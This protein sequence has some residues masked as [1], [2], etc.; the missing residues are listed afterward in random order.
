MSMHKVIAIT[1]WDYDDAL[2]QT[3]TLPYVRIITE[4]LESPKDLTLVTFDKNDCEIKKANHREGDKFRRVSFRYTPFGLTSILRM[5]FATIK[6]YI[7]CKVNK[8]NKIHVWGSTAGS[9]GFFLSKILKSELIIDSF[10]PHAESMVENGTWDR[11][12]FQFR[13][14]FYLE[15]LQA[16]KASY[17]IG[18]SAGML[19]YACANYKISKK[20][21]FV[22]PSCVDLKLFNPDNVKLKREELGFEKS[23]IIC[24]YAGKFGGIYLDQEIFD[25]FHESLK[26]FGKRFKVLLLTNETKDR[27][28]K[29]Q[30]KSNIPDG[31]IHSHFLPHH[32]VPEYM[33]IADFAINPV[34]PVPTKRYCTSIKDGEYWAMGLPVVITPNISDD[35]EIIYNKKIGVVLENLN[36]SSYQKALGELNLLLADSSSKKMRELIR[37]VAMEYRNYSIA[38]KIYKE[39]YS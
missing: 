6:L 16:L 25:F 12:S 15:K 31:V 23:D 37:G 29:K 27:L 28:K 24:V 2:V 5:F 18:T 8:I 32:L 30:Q 10:E 21:F 4:Y 19:E 35:S 36:S 13:F 34:K 1:Y 17:L 38:H 39:I 9:I 3:Y 22:K 26:Y 20:N 11:S 33:G 14:L 7:Y